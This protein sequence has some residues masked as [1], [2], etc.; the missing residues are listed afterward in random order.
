MPSN[1]LSRSRSTHA[2][3]SREPSPDRTDKDSSALSSWARYLKSKYGTR[4]TTDSPR[5][6]ITSSGTSSYTSPSSSSSLT[7]SSAASRRLSLGLPLRQANELHSS[8][9][10]SK[11]GQSSL[12]PTP[13]AGNFVCQIYN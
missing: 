3:K 13:V 10:D 1:E 12:P 2:L 4:S 11:N 5:D 8:E 7:P 6:G 9:D